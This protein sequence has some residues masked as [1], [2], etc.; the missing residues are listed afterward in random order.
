MR[1]GMV[2]PPNFTIP[3]DVALV[4]ALCRQ[5][6]DVTLLCR[7]ERPNERILDEYPIERRYYRL[8]EQ[9]ISERGTNPLT[10]ALKGLEH[11]FDS[12]RLLRDARRGG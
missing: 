3:Y 7:Q 8:S 10:M 9:L 2:D 11:I 12:A 4:T 6:C 1:L 5:G